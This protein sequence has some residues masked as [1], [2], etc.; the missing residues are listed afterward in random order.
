MMMMMMTLMFESI[1]NGFTPAC[2]GDKCDSPSH[3]RLF[4]SPGS[5][6]TELLREKLQNLVYNIVVVYE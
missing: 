1:A 2:D 3:G 6:S 5:N 4:Q